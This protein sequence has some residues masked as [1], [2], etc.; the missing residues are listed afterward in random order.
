MRRLTSEN[1]IRGLQ[2]EI[3]FCFCENSNLIFFFVCLFLFVCL[4]VST[5]NGKTAGITFTRAA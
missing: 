3:Y 5:P 1:P 4:L 2:H